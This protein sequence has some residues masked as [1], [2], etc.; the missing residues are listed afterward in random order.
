[1]VDAPDVP[2]HALEARYTDTLGKY[3]VIYAC[4]LVLAGLQFVIGYSHIDITAKF[5]RML[6]VA[7]VFP[8]AS[9]SAI[10]PPRGLRFHSGSARSGESNR[11]LNETPSSSLRAS[12]TTTLI[13]PCE[14]VLRWPGAGHGA[15]T[16]IGS[17][18][19]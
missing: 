2:K 13:S 9:S 19:A 10:A 17:A 6:F 4:I 3:I 5:A 8:F 11:R 14:P 16:R 15:S 18:R 1:M 7:I 12:L